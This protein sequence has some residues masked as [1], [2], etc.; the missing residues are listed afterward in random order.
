MDAW[1]EDRRDVLAAQGGDRD[2]FARLVARYTRR[3]HDLARRMLR[4]PHEA[5]DVVQHAFLNAWQAL[6]RFDTERPFRNWLLRIASN[7]CRNRIAARGRRQELRPRGGDDA[8]PEIEDPL[9]LQPAEAP[10][11]AARVRRAMEALPE[12]YRLPVILHYVQ[13][14]PLKDVSE[15]TGAPVATVKTWLHRG[16][17]ALARLLAAPET[18]GPGP[19]TTPGN[20]P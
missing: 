19:G 16:R 9:P 4:D 5:E 7:L 1:L 20:E 14:L 11:G 15:I 17:A 8:L 2:A 12:R 18:S 13:D 10:L 6:D 3:L